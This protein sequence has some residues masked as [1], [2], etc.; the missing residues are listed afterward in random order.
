MSIFTSSVTKVPGIVA[1]SPANDECPLWEVFTS[2][3]VFRSSC[4]DFFT[5]VAFEAFH[6]SHGGYYARKLGSTERR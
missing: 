6:R 3:K 4:N 2:W 1:Y 5:C